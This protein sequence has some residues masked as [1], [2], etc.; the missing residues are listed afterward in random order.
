MA[1]VHYSYTDNRT[2]VLFNLN[3]IQNTAWQQKQI[4]ELNIDYYTGISDLNQL[5]SRYSPKLQQC[6]AGAST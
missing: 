3:D 1:F 4:D 2:G 5:F 6:I